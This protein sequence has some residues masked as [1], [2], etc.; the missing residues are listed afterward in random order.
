MPYRSAA[1]EHCKWR[2]WEGADFAREKIYR[3]SKL[4]RVKGHVAGI[5]RL[6]AGSNTRAYDR[7]RSHSV[8]P[9]FLR[10]Q[11]ATR[12]VSGD[13]FPRSVRLYSAYMDSILSRVSMRNSCTTLI[14]HNIIILC[15]QR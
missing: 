4:L 10:A 1:E 5:Y 7:P 2:V 8:R 3:P 13:G 9:R 11:V 14:H 12:Q 6:G 15:A